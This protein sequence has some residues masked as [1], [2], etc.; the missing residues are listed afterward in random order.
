VNGTARVQGVLTTTA[1]AVVNGV[2]IGIG[3]ASSPN[4]STKVGRSTFTN[5]TGQHNSAFGSTAMG[6]NTSGANNSA[7]G[8]SSLRNNTTGGSN[9]AFGLES[10]GGNGS[11]NSAFGTFALKDNSASSNS[12]F[13]TRALG[14]NTSATNNSGFGYF[15]LRFNTT[16]ASNSAFG[17]NSLHSNIDGSN[18]IALGFNAGR[19]AGA[20]ITEMT[21]VNNSIYLGFQTR[22]LNATGSTNEIVIGYNVVGLGSNTTVLGNTSTTFGRWYGSLL[23]GTTTNAASSILTME[24]TTQGFLPPRMTATQRDAIASPATGLI[25]YQ[26]DGVEGLYVRTSTAWRALAMV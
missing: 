2:N 19:L 23:L 5:N 9:C 24:S 20:G 16:G 25:V 3:G 1:D 7:F 18:N 21:S 12:A 4:N 6:V 8:S 22:G 10:L 11:N 15:S 17:T 14:A 26:T 13:G